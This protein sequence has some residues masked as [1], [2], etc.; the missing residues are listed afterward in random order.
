M[1]KEEYE[2]ICGFIEKEDLAG[3]KK[4][5]DTVM[6]NNNLLPAR[7]AVMELVNQDSEKEYPSYYQRVELHQGIRKYYNG[8]IAKIED[9]L[10]I[11]HM[12]S[13]IFYLNNEK[14]IDKELN[15]IITRNIKYS[16]KENRDN[17][18][19]STKKY[20][21]KVD[22]NYITP[23]VTISDNTNGITDVEV[24]PEDKS[25]S[26]L[27]P[28]NLYRIAHELL[29][30]QV[31]QYVKEPGDALYLKSPLGKAV[32]GSRVRKRN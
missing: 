31:E 8:V 29:G 23:V 28:G 10:L 22:S 9:G 26:A 27:V 30:K 17:T 18:I 7:R 21:T 15:D 20:L 19:A 2:K 14:I 32:I 4:Y 16:N 1:R 24:W 13:N 6:D 3:L 25:F 5:V 11:F 12:N